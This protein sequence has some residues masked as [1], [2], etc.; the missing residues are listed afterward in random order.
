MRRSSGHSG[1]NHWTYPEIPAAASYNRIIPRQAIGEY[2]AS[3]KE[4][5]QK[6]T[7][8]NN[9]DYTQNLFSQI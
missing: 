8:A 3:V 9:K 4:K 7:P 6:L 5:Y 2:F 1:L